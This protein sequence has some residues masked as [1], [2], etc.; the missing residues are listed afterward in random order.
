M[1]SPASSIG[2]SASATSPKEAFPPVSRAGAEADSANESSDMAALLQ[3][4]KRSKKKIALI[5]KIFL[6][7]MFMLS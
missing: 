5:T 1:A 3:A 6:R 2:A 7:V 4:A